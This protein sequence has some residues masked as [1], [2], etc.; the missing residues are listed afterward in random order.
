[1]KRN[2]NANDLDDDRNTSNG[3]YYF[4]PSTRDWRLLII[5][6]HWV[7]Q[8]RKYAREP[9]VKK[10]KANRFKYVWRLI[11]K[12]AELS[13]SLNSRSSQIPNERLR[14]PHMNRNSSLSSR[15]RFFRVWRVTHLETLLPS[16]IKIASSNPLWTSDSYKHRTGWTPKNVQQFILSNNSYHSL[17]FSGKNYIENMNNMKGASLFPKCILIR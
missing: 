12:K 4:I 1:M 8:V 11:D 13:Y 16:M 9:K 6:Q 5:S 17:Q 10:C 2:W 15:P 7:L 3:T 14:N